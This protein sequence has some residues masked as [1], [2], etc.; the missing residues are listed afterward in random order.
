VGNAVVDGAEYLVEPDP[1]GWLRLRM[2]LDW[3]DEAPGVLL[4]AGRWVEVLA[5]PEIRARVAATA[6]AVAERYAGDPV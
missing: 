3:P 1:Q 6:R 4:G 2:R 5:P